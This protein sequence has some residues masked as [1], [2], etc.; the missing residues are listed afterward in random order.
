MVKKIRAC[1]LFSKLLFHFYQNIVSYNHSQN[2]LRLFD[3]LPNFP[4]AT[5]ATMRDYYL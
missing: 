2:L 5:S 4:F 1:V 3:V